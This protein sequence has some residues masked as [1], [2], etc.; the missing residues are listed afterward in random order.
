MYYNVYQLRSKI[1]S[2]KLPGSSQSDK[3]ELDPLGKFSDVD[4][5]E[6]GHDIAEDTEYSDQV[7][8]NSDGSCTEIPF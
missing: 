2:Y 1:L 3:R 7:R 8:N 6:S 4:L 5:S